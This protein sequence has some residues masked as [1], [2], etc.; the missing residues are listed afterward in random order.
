MP[1]V[2]TA[3]KKSKGS[4][5][6]AFSVHGA[7][8]PPHGPSEPYLRFLDLRGLGLHLGQPLIDKEGVA[9]GWQPPCSK[10]FPQADPTSLA[11][12]KYQR[13]ATL[14]KDNRKHLPFKTKG[15]QRKTKGKGNYYLDRTLKPAFP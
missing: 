3:G 10:R 2:S 1:G 6:P 15:T 12:R 8:T 4:Q 9:Q 5:L 7:A 11:L 14:S 13:D